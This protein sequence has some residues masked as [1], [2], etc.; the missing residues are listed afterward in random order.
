MVYI[1][2]EVIV[3]SLMVQVTADED[4]LEICFASDQI[5]VDLVQS[6]MYSNDQ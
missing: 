2:I 3:I 4:R 1:T 5:T 6:A